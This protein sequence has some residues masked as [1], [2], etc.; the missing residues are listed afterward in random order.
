M[1]QVE[2]PTMGISPKPSEEEEGSH[3]RRP[4]LNTKVI[5]SGLQTEE[6]L[7]LDQLALT[8]ADEAPED[9]L[10]MAEQYPLLEI[11]EPVCN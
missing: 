3:E 6:T 8:S 2:L 11:E 5:A 9:S 7:L 10:R 4:L 1:V